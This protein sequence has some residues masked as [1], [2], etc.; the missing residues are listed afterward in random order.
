MLP[1]FGFLVPRSA[2]YLRVIES[3]NTHLF[4]VPD[5]STPLSFAFA[6]LFFI[7]RGFFLSFIIS[8]A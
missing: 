5:T 6:T 2:E 3:R 7:E 4:S 1:R 8:Y